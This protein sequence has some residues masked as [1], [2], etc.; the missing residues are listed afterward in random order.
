MPA[1]CPRQVVEAHG[2]FDAAIDLDHEEAY[3]SVVV[4]RRQ[5]AA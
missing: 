1:I 2:D 4:L 3:R 5:P